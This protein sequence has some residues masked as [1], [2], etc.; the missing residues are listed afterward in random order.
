[1][2]YFDELRLKNFKD[3]FKK[4]N[5][6]NL[7]RVEDQPHQNISKVN[8]IDFDLDPKKKTAI[9][10]LDE[11]LIYCSIKCSSVD[12]VKIVTPLSDQIVSSKALSS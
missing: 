1:M 5:V 11:T 6:I 4:F 7:L 3:N 12:A 10:D 9:M 8:L 2:S